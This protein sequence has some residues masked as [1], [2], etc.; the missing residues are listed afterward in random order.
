M[1]LISHRGNLNGPDLKTENKPSQIESVIKKGFNVEIDVWLINN[2]YWLGHDEPQYL[3][4]YNWL[5]EIKSH[6]YIHCKN[7]DLVEF[8]FQSDMNYFWHEDDDMTITSF[9]HLWCHPKI[10]PIK[11]CIA[12]LPEINN[13]NLESCSGICSDY[14][15]NYHNE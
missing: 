12:V 3:T 15:I 8:L 14:I 1:I 4:S 10:K 6:L 7:H 2:K 13:W 9:G 5:K 11:N